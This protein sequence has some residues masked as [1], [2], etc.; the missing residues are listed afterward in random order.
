MGDIILTSPALEALKTALPA[1]RIVFVTK[2]AFV[3]LVQHNPH[4]HDVVGLGKGEST[5]ALA[6]RLRAYEPRAVLDLHGKSRSRVLS[7]LVGANQHVRWHKRPWQDA[8]PV[9]LG[10]RPYHAKMLIA[11]RYHAAVE[12]LVG[13]AVSPGHL[14][15][16]VG[17]PEQSRA[18]AVLAQAGLSGHAR[19]LG[20]SPGANWATKRWPTDRYAALA[21]Q[22]LL[23]GYEVV[24]TGS[25][26]EAPLAAQILQHASGVRDLS[27]KLSLTELA[28]VI[29]RC[30]AFVAN[31]S[32]PMHM[33]RALG[34]PTLAIFGSTDP[35]QFLFDQHGLLFAGVP[36]SPC[37]FY[38]RKA[39]PKGHFDCMQK[40]DVAEAW[41]KLVPL[42]ERGGA[43]FVRG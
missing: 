9:R 10:L 24:L 23:A 43:E 15:Y 3:G 25:Q 40:L 17:Q 37:H 22:A 2:Q 16:W 18:D 19:I 12:A 14:R 5:Q 27:G 26:E 30:Q 28:G 11:D 20:M 8:I 1:S 38:G 13:H 32:G 21:Q 42:L 7:Y 39:C 29:K 4:L 33:A 34:V 35:K 31:D 6:K 41:Q 36:C